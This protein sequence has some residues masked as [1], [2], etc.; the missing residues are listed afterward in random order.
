MRLAAT[1]S[2]AVV[3]FSSK[4]V[5]AGHSRGHK[6][7]VFLLLIAVKIKVSK[8]LLRLFLVPLNASQLLQ[9]LF[10]LHSGFRMIS[11]PLSVSSRRKKRSTPS[12]MQTSLPSSPHSNPSPTTP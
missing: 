3:L 12:T 5:I 8:Y 7:L 1:Q 10:F 2:W 11:L 9:R 6:H 4:W